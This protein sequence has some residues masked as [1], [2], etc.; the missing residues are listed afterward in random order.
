MERSNVRRI[1]VSGALG[2][3]SAVMAITPLGYLPWFG[4]ASLTIMHI[5]VI[6]AA[7]LEGPIAGTAVGLIFGVTSLVKAAT[8]PIGPLDP[9]FANPLVSILPRLA[10]GFAAWG[11]FRL[12]RGKVTPLAAGVA[13]AVG[14]MVNTALVLLALGLVGT[15]ELTG[16]FGVDAGALPAILGSIALTNGLVEAAAAAVFTSSVVSAWKGIESARGRSKL[17]GEGS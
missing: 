14:S 16:M 3:V 6:I 15:R 12:F 5:P 9:L 4:G 7:V 17:S 11:A 13:G 10:I 2:A 1:V 8:A